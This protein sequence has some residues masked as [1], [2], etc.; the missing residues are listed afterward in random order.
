[1]KLLVV[2]KVEEEYGYWHI[3]RKSILFLAREL[4]RI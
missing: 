2:C 3:F 1:M 4:V